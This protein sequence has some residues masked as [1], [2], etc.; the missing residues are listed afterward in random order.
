MP[1]AE[2]FT[3]IRRIVIALDASAPSLA[4]LEAAATLAA[5]VDAEL[6]GVF[7]EDVNLVH[8]AGLPFAA[9]VGV[10]SA[11]ARSLAPEEMERLLAL[12]RRRAEQAL[13]RVAQRL[14]LRWSFRVVRGQIVSELLAAAIE[15]DMMA[16]GATGTQMRRRAWLGS[17]AQAIL[18]QTVRPVLITL[19]GASLRLPIAVVCS[20]S[21]GSMQ[22][23]A[24]AAYVAERLDGGELIVLLLADDAEQEER[25][26]QAITARLARANTKAR[27]GWLV[28]ADVDELARRLRAER[29][30]TLVLAGDAG[31][32]DAKSVRRLL[33]RTDVTVLVAGADQGDVVQSARTSAGS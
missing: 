28:E 11:R 27:Y 19:R 5:R 4:A 32:F 29:A 15:A 17:T 24:L 8:L 18:A 26:R 9:E 20:D 3:P 31:V 13:A 1:P 22:A 25:L 33:E 21:T 14:R 2:T 30:G 10:L 23:L 6:L 16:L 7:I 12:Q